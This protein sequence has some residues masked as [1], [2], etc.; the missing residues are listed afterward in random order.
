M[1]FEV[2]FPESGVCFCVEP[3]QT[4]VEVAALHGLEILTGCTDGKCGTCVVKVLEGEVDHRDSVLTPEKRAEGWMCA[5][6][7]RAA[8]QRLSLEIW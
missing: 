7:S 6:V 2:E 8:G 4:I 5:C 1:R 3:G